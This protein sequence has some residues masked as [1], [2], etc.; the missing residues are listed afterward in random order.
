MSLAVTLITYYY[1]FSSPTLSFIPELKPSFL[2]ILPTAAF[3]FLLQNLLHDSPRLSLL[4]LTYLVLLF[5][6]S[7]LQF[8]V[9][10]AVR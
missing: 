2:Q 7:V 3:L 1:Y 10:V 4:L 5:S 8:L 9:V 6:F